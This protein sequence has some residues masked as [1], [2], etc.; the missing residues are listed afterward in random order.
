DGVDQDCDGAELCFDDDDGDGALDAS[1]DTRVSA[2]LDCLDPNEGSAA[3]PTTDCDDADAAVRPGVAERPGD[4]VDQDCDGAELCFDDDDDDGFL[5]ASGDTRVSADADCLDPNEGA[6]ADPTIDCDDARAAVHPG[7]VEIPDDG[8]DQ[9]CDGAELCFDDADDDGFLPPSR[10][11][12][13]SADLDCLDPREGR[14]ADPATDCDDARTAVHPGAAELP[15]D[16]VDQDCD[17]AELCFDDD[18]DDGFL[19]ASGDTRVSADADC[20]DPN[21]GASADPTTDCDD[22]RAA[23]HPGAAEIPGD[24]IDQSCDGA[25]LC[26]DDEDDDGFLDGAGDTRPSVDA[27]CADPREGR[28][29]DPTTDC[30]DTRAA[31]HPGAA[32]VPGDGV[33]QDCDSAELCL[34]D[35]DD[36]GFLD[37]SGDTRASADLD[38]LDPREGTISDPTT[39]CDD[40][41]ATVHPGAA[42]VVGDGVDQDC[43]RAELCFDDG[44]DDGFLD[45][46]GRA[47]P[48]ADVDCLDPFEGRRADP[49]TDCDDGDPAVHPG[50]PE[51]AGD[52]VDQDCDGA[53]VCLRDADDDGFLDG[54]G[55]TVTSTDPDCDD[56]GEALTGAPTGD[57]DDA[58]AD[59]RPG[60]AEVA[61][62]GVDQNCNGQELCY[63]DAD[64]DGYLSETGGTRTSADADCDDPFEGTHAD[65]TTDCDDARAAVHPGAAEVVGDG[66]D[67][68]CD[69][70][71]VCYDDDDDDGFLD[72]SGDT[73]ASVDADC[74]DP[75]EGR[76]TDPTT[77]CDDTRASIA[78]G[79]TE[80]V[81]D[82]IDQTCD[83]RELCFRDVDDD[84][85]LPASPGTVLSTD[86]DCRDPFE[87]TAS[88]PTTDCDD[89][90]PAAHPGAP[91]LVGDGVD[92]DCDGGERCADDPDDDGFLAASPGVRASADPDCDD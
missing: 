80:V 69:S 78:P 61:G 64:D 25:E 28:A 31:V 40:A 72:T 29:T 88:D 82:G 44:D 67:Q 84:G 55:A 6:S 87:G 17:G 3:T 77:D 85:F 90:N 30:D 10:P 22:A 4:G 76:S 70:R 20:L 73:R 56:P 15:G 2:D 83:G 49:T 68:D 12:R 59:V 89:A 63:D 46:A 37:A 19:D 74:D 9:D 18:D 21:E 50:V 24:E 92:E 86:A 39:D 26:L 53:E 52:G 71:E 75:F 35:D 79:A 38:C 13:A 27:D 33:D 34:D 62:D 8:V 54:A 57:C 91:E 16:G 41:Q 45:G 43:D 66:V 1:G 14:A 7:A 81:G 58:R 47:R 5:D 23:V 42:E 32:E 36:D 60:A 51:R 65:P 11:T 48:S